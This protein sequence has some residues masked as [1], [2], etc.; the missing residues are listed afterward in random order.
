MIISFD[1]RIPLAGNNGDQVC[2]KIRSKTATMIRLVPRLR[3]ATA[4]VDGDTLLLALRIAGDDRW[5][6]S[7]QQRKIVASLVAQ[8]GLK[9]MDIKL[10]SALIEKGPGVL[11]VA[12]G[13]T[14][15]ARRPRH[16]QT[17]DGIPSVDGVP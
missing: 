6:I 12:E 14:P 7:A 5:R 10:V 3:G 16:S 17:E 11:T 1:Y 13:R 9:P 4:T 2:A 8:A 15:M